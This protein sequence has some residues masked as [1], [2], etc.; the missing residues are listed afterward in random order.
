M[1]INDW[2]YFTFPVHWKYSEGYEAP[3]AVCNYQK[4]SVK[5]DKEYIDLPSNGS[6]VFR[7]RMVHYPLNSQKDVFIHTSF[8]YDQSEK[9]WI[10]YLLLYKYHDSWILVDRIK[11]ME[12]F[13]ALQFTKDEKAFLV[14]FGSRISAFNLE[15][16]IENV[17][18]SVE[19]SYYYS[20][21]HLAQD[22]RYLLATIAPRKGKGGLRFHLYDFEINECIILDRGINQIDLT[23]IEITNSPLHI[24]LLTDNGR[25]MIK[26]LTL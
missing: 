21:A 15:N 26:I 13:R 2:G 9:K 14:L 4:I 19:S 10:G 25:I 24:P 8:D 1:A 18:I 20:N 16:F 3:M 5:R 17:L 23:N 6:E 7:D 11:V 12:Y 22:G